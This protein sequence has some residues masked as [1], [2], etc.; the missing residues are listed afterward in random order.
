MKTNAI[1]RIVLLSLAIVLLMGIL[2]V[3]IGLRTF[4]VD[5][6]D[7][8]SSWASLPGGTVTSSGEVSAASVK[9][10]SIEWVGGSVKIQPGDTDKITFS[11]S[12]AHSEKDRMVYKLS[13]NTLSI[14]FRN[15]HNI[16]NWGWNSSDMNKDL[17]V[18]VPR[19]WVC[20]EVSIDSVSA[21][22]SAEGLTA[23]TFDI[24]NVSGACVLTDCSLGD[25]DIDT[26]SGD[27]KFSGTLKQCDCSSVSA[28]CRLELA[29]AAREIDFDAV[30]GDLHVT[31]PQGTGFSA[32][33]D[34]LS[35]E[36]FTGDSTAHGDRY[37]SGDGECRISAST[38]SGD[39]HIYHS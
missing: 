4:S 11:E 20:N 28:S 18:T 9:R 13:G 1:V 6:R 33:L 7:T 35:G 3:G 27:V 31:L 12:G 32:D 34:T 26:V 14:H 24:D 16:F 15:S 2:L 17:V 30:S 19:D 38:T 10:L 8:I 36:I 29:A 22:I 39:I 5:Y 21:R 23:D 37:S 25:L